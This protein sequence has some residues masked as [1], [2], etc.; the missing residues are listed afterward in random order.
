MDYRKLAM[1]RNYALT[2][3]ELRRLVFRYVLANESKGPNSW[4]LKL[5]AKIGSVP[6]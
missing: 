6:S 4:I 3:T 2:P 1:E 5:L